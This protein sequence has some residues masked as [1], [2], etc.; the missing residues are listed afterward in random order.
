METWP[1]TVQI[2]SETEPRDH[3]S[4]LK[5]A[6]STNDPTGP[7]LNTVARTE[8]NPRLCTLRP[9]SIS[10]LLDCRRRVVK[11]E[12]IVPTQ[13]DVTAACGTELSATRRA[14]VNDT[15]TMV[16]YSNSAD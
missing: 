8:S 12:T 5:S 7:L 10:P 15:K 13:Q 14:K 1:N 4:A 6:C 16:S 3:N 11:P 2:R 9:L